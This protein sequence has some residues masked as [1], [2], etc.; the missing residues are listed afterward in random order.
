MAHPVRE[1]RL[2]GDDRVE[3]LADT[4]Q[5]LEDGSLDIGAPGLL[6]NDHDAEGQALRAE[7]LTLE[8]HGAFTYVPDAGYVGSD[9]FVY[10]VGDLGGPGGTASVELDGYEPV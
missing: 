10:R 2:G 6:A 8:A 5:V 7:H 1:E 3:V 4:Y 9:V